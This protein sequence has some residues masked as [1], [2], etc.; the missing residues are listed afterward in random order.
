MTSRPSSTEA[1]LKAFVVECGGDPDEWVRQLRELRETQRR[2]EIEKPRDIPQSRPQ[3]LCDAVPDPAL[4]VVA[5]TENAD[6]PAPGTRPPQHPRGQRARKVGLAAV[7]LVFAAVTALIV[8]L[9]G[10]RDP[11]ALPDTTPQ[12]AA[13]G[14]GPFRYDET[15]GPG[16]V[17][18]FATGRQEQ[19][20]Q[21]EP[22]N[23]VDMEHAWAPGRSDEPRWTIPTC[24][25][26]ML[27]S[28]PSTEA[29]R[30]QWQND[31]VWKFFDVPAGA[32]CTF[33]I[34]IAQST[35]S[36]YNATYDWTNGEIVGD[37]VDANAFP[38]NQA[39]YVGSWYTEG[40]HTYS[41]GM[42]YLMLTDQRGDNPASANAPLTASE[43]RLTCS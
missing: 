8:T 33:H 1:V 28:Q 30:Y 36:K 25:N 39:A 11:A 41:T 27:Y 38:V 22:D 3:L 14:G 7:M 12:R 19:V 42:A 4:S 18:V 24:T 16:C 37:W 26:A 20:A 5:Q 32:P 40:P 15:T 29:N 13:G 6:E 2:P 23:S 31:Y 10:H 21:V 34:Y 9:E 43:V 17:M 35:L